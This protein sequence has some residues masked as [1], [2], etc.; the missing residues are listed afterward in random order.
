MASVMQHGIVVPEALADHLKMK[1]NREGPFDYM[2]EQ[3]GVIPNLEDLTLLETFLRDS[4][5]TENDSRS[6][7]AGF[8]FLGQFIDHDI[9]LMELKMSQ[10][11]LS[12]RFPVTAFVNRRTPF[13]E[14][15]SVYGLGLEAQASGEILFHPDGKFR[16]GTDTGGIEQDVPRD[17]ETE[18]ALIGDPRNDENKIIQ[19]IHNL[20]QRLH[21]RFIDEGRSYAD[22]RLSVMRHYQYMILNDYLARTIRQDVLKW[23]VEHRAPAYRALSERHGGVPVMPL[24]FSV[25][26]FR[27]GHSQVRSGYALNDAFGAPIF[28]DNPAVQDLNGGRK[29]EPRHAID[30]KFFFG[31]IGEGT[32]QPSRRIDPLLSPALRLLKSPGIP[33]ET[34]DSQA[35]PRSLA[36]RNLFRAAQTGLISGQSAAAAFGY[37]PLADDHLGLDIVP[38]PASQ[39]LIRHTPLWYYVLQEA[40][41]QEDGQ[42]LG[43]VGSRILAE[44]FVG[45]MLAA[46]YSV[47]KDGWKPSNPALGTMEGIAAHVTG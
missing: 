35:S 34:V 20:F 21:N 26:A 39:K 32:V 42:R 43:E 40:H 2:I 41:V 44:T 13:F 27:F 28:S 15:D 7:P 31:T 8:T 38:P 6:I 22:A 29:L 33:N 36:K 3:G 46:H 37:K 10:D 16:L 24:E 25:A 5:G 4:V 18:R 12:R 17:A 45:G 9:T 23:V 1:L 19:Q 14:L 47:L 30:W 11:D